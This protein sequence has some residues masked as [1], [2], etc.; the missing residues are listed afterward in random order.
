VGGGF[1]VHPGGHVLGVGA[2]VDGVDTFGAGVSDK[3]FG[4]VTGFADEVGGGVASAEGVDSAADAGVFDGVVADGVAE[5]E[6]ETFGDVDGFS[7][8]L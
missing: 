4:D 5:A 6:A 3:G 8:R 2:D 1:S 7:C